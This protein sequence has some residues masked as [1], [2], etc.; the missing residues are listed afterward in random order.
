M[1]GPVATGA[2]TTPNDDHWIDP[3]RVSVAICTKGRDETV[4]RAVATVLVDPTEDVELILVDQNDDDRLVELLAPFAADRRLTHVRLD[5]P[6]AGRA[7][8]VALELA[9][10]P[11]V[12]FTDD[13]CTVPVGWARDMTELFVSRPLLGVV[14]CSVVD[15]V[16]A[17]G[18][19]FTPDF[20]IPNEA[21]FHRWNL[22]SRANRLGIG[23]GM[24]VRRSTAL[25]LG[26]FDPMMGPGSAFPSADDR[27]L[28]VR[29]LFS[30]SHVMLS[31]VPTVDHHGHRP[32]GDAARALSRRD[33]LALGAMFA[34]S[35]DAR[36]VVSSAQLL[37][38][39]G[40]TVGRIVSDSLRRRRPTGFGKIVSVLS[41][42]LTGRRAPRDRAAVS[43]IDTADATWT[44]EPR[45]RADVLVSA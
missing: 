29:A 45:G 10:R 34:K 3:E 16:G 32:D 40:E 4:A 27:E 37:V 26:G 41:G 19:G 5:T 42:L 33:H 23:A 35:I 1:G 44:I 7:R 15:A 24:A 21:V 30:G 12:C 9:T 8:N 2:A 28:A 6:G 22:G 39:L 38:F 36:P 11:I 18:D 25:A 43:Y 14:F 20:V 17:R 13:D 31:P